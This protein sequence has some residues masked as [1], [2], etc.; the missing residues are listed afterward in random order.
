MTAHP[1]ARYF[2]RAAAALPHVSAAL[3]L[4]WRAAPG[5]TA[6]WIALLAVQGLLPIALVYLTRP[7]VNGIA[8]AV[9]DRADW[10]PVVVPAVLMAVVLLLIELLRGAIQYVRTVEAD[11]VQ[12][13]ITSLVQQKSVEADLA[14]YESPDFYDGLHRAR[15]E[16][17]YRPVALL[18]TLGS[19]LQSG[20][21]LIAMLAVLARLG[22]WLPAALLISTLPAFAMV[23]RH[24][25]L[26]H[27]FRTRAT[28]I[29]RRAW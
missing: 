16:A 13:Q 20:V 4:I 14:F 28:P 21:T 7:I 6:V 24:A 8:A 11:L 19:L 23:L 18:E 10:R 27:E 22:V 2:R 12:D 5:W 9:R 25:V 3:R 29:E 15:A 26:Q 17:G 1:A